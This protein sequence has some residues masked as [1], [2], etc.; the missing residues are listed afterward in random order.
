MF[1]HFAKVMA[2]FHSNCPTIRPEVGRRSSQDV[3]VGGLESWSLC[4]SAPEWWQEATSSGGRDLGTAF[5]EISPEWYLREV[6][7]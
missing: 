7:H 4:E 2:S 3:E 6:L 1:G 5:T